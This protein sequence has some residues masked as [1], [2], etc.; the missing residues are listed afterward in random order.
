M[1][2]VVTGLAIAGPLALIVWWTVPALVGLAVGSCQ[3][4]PMRGLTQ[5][6]LLGPIGVLGLCVQ[7]NRA[8]A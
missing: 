3:G 1:R 4:R 5:G 6:F 7:R 8:A 2:E